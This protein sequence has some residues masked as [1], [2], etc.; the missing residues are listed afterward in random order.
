MIE[1][2]YLRN[3]SDGATE[4]WA[5]CMSCHKSTMLATNHKSGVDGQP[6]CMCDHC[7]EMLYYDGL[8]EAFVKQIIDHGWSAAIQW[9]IAQKTEVDE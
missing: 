8:R 1:A 3:V 2:A 6:F 4:I 5:K 7:G 9:L